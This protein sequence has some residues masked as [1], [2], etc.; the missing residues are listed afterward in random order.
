MLP[1][2][3]AFF[4]VSYGRFFEPFLGSGAIL[5]T[6]APRN[7]VG[8]DT[9]KPLMEI[10]IT[11]RENPRRLVDWY[12]GRYNQIGSKTKEEVYAIMLRHFQ[13]EGETL[14]NEQVSDRLLLTY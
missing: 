13:K 14:E 6:V 5:A 3:R 1:K 10:W 7:G 9:F 12:A 11:L 4:P 2:S 8:S